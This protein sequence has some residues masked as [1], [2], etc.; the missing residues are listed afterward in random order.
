M[1]D[2]ADHRQKNLLN[3]TVEQV[4]PLVKFQNQEMWLCNRCKT[5]K[6]GYAIGG[7]GDQF[8]YTQSLIYLLGGKLVAKDKKH[9][10]LCNEEIP[11]YTI[12]L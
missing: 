4:L 12:F 1:T 6:C 2:K 3:K 9:S 5:K 10:T 8:Q 7:G 11:K